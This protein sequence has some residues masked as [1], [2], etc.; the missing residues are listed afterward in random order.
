MRWGVK[1]AAVL[2]TFI[3]RNYSNY[4]ALRERS[5][6]FIN[7]GQN[8]VISAYLTGLLCASLGHSVCYYS[9]V[10]SLTHHCRR[11]VKVYI[12]APLIHN[13]KLEYST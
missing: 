5:G 10:L 12:R 6:A 11:L 4:L 2:A 13:Y 3:I 9:S 7:V 1:T 8:G